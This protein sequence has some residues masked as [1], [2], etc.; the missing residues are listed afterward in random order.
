MQ[1]H[2]SSYYGWLKF[3]QS[4]REQEDQV[5]AKAIHNLWESAE[6][7]LGYRNIHLDLL[8]DKEQTLTCGRDRVLRLMRQLN[9][10]AIRG[11]KKP[12]GMYGGWPT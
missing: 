12:Q 2:P 7:I 11:Y 6:G 9:I 4:K 5:L 8:D 3:P 10:Q 1:V